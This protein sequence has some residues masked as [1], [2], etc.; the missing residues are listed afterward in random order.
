MVSIFGWM[1]TG[2]AFLSAVFFPSA[3]VIIGRE[4]VMN[5]LHQ[6]NAAMKV[7]ID[8]FSMGGPV[9]VLRDGF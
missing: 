2:W 3:D 5:K 1:G 8:G 9:N 6:V 4:N 7:S